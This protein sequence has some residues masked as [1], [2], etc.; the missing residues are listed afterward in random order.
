MQTPG[1][2]ERVIATLS[3][4]LS[5]QYEITILVKDEPLSFYKLNKQVKVESLYHPLTF[6][7]QNPLS[8]VFA[9]A[10]TVI[11]NNGSLKNYVSTHR[12]DFFYVAHPLQV[13]EIKLA[14]VKKDKLVISEH[15]SRSAYNFFYKAIKRVLYK[16]CLRYVVPT[17][18]DTQ[19]YQ[20]AK[21]PAVYIP[22]F[23]SDLPYCL[24]SKREN[25]VLTIGRLTADKQHHLLIDIWKRIIHFYGFHNWKLNIVGSGELEHELREQVKKYKLEP[26][27]HFFPPSAHVEDYY[28][29]ASLFALTSLAE[30]FGMVL[31]E[32]ISFGLPCVSFDCPSGPRDIIK[33]GITGYLIQPNNVA[34]FEGTLISLLENK[35]L[36]SRM[37]MEAYISSK[38]WKDSFIMKKWEDVLT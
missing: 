25:T 31:L 18:G 4:R 20:K 3:E 33:H 21:L 7:M 12:F 1:G 29:K 19:A 5:S 8:R 32:A 26:Y 10:S 11:S 30:G 37:G 28:K 34:K 27:V 2:V 17:I 14:G 22:H 6:N 15:G 13:L 35:A 16:G 23:R 38:K 24:G 9:A 36:I